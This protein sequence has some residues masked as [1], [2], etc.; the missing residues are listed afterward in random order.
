MTA[1]VMLSGGVSPTTCALSMTYASVL[2]PV[3]FPQLSPL[4]HHYHPIIPSPCALGKQVI[5]YRPVLLFY[6]TSYPY[7]LAI[8][9]SYA[10]VSDSLLS[11]DSL[12]SSRVS[13][14]LD[15]FLL[16]LPTLTTGS[17]SSVR[18]LSVQ[19]K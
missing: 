18:V 7:C 9:S 5:V 3:P 2:A 15:C 8:A 16:C 11:Y 14:C 13:Y 4:V 19:T 6:A 17:I 10:I 12:L 1:L